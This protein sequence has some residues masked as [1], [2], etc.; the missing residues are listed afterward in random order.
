M[1]EII[2][3]GDADDLADWVETLV[4]SLDLPTRLIE[5]GVTESDVDTAAEQAVGEHL[6][7]T[8]PRPLNAAEFRDILHK[9]LI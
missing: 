1:K 5:L 7:Q 3:L 4:Q 9:A 2:G 6:N 8:N